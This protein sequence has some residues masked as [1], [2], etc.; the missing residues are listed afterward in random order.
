MAGGSRIEHVR[1]GMLA[2]SSDGKCLGKVTQVHTRD[3]TETYLEVTPRG[4]L[5]KPWQ[6]MIA[7]Q[8]LFLPGSTVADVA[9]THVHV[10]LDAKTAKGCTWRPSWIPHKVD[11]PT[12]YTMIGG[13]GGG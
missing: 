1:I 3:D 4:N 9:G 6:L 5:W 12:T 2:L 13:G 7:V 10:A 11:D 8:R